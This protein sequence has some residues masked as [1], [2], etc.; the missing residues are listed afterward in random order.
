MRQDALLLGV[1]YGKASSSK[2]VPPLQEGLSKKQSQG[3]RPQTKSE[4]GSAPASTDGRVEA[5]IQD[6]RAAAPPTMEGL[7]VNMEQS[8]GFN[9]LA[10]LIRQGDEPGEFIPK[11]RIEGEHAD[12][13]RTIAAE[14]MIERNGR[15][16]EEMLFKLDSHLS[17]A[18][19][20]N[21]RDQFASVISGSVGWMDEGGGGIGGWVKSKLGGNEG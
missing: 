1:L 11:A 10:E 14:K 16:D 7:L 19:D 3:Q 15:L 9:P 13:I 12:L 5:G 4:Q 18:V 17:L 2:E 6:T 21:G 8:E 20:G